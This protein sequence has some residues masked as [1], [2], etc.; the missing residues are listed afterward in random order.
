MEI[1]NAILFSNSFCTT[2][3]GCVAQS[4]A[5]LIQEPEVLGSILGPA[6]Y[7]F[8]LLLLIKE[9]QLTVNVESMYTAN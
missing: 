7:F 1:W 8:F 4:E 2:E 5:C 9:G 3:L 6:T